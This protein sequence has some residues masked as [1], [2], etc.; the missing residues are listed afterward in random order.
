MEERQSL[1][2][3]SR[4]DKTSSRALAQLKDT[5]EQQ[6]QKTEKLAEDKNVQS[7]RRAEVDFADLDMSLIH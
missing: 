5:Y 2:T 3:L 6:Q 4:D 1:E 7:Q